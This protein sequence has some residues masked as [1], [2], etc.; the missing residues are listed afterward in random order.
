M[1]PALAQP[2]LWTRA[3]YD[4]MVEAGI[5]GPDDKIE[6]IEGEI[7]PMSPQ[8]SPHATGVAL[9][10]EA[11]RQVFVL[12]AHCRCQAPLAVS[13]DSEPE[14]DL[15]VVAGSIRDHV[16]AHPS[17][18]LLVIEISDTTLAFDRSV[19]KRL[20]ARAGIPEYWIVNLVERKVEVHREPE[21]DEYTRSF[22]AKPG[23]RV[24][25]LGATAEVAVD[26]LLP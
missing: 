9:A 4:S 11:L 21:G 18:A 17:T 1:A 19:K 24:S 25:P 5:F 20:Y 13:A 3:E 14:P 6:L 26:D 7:V 12:G 2:R 8:K 23:E 15:A 22:H 16:N 10:Q